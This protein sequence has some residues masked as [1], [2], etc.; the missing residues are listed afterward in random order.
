[1]PTM[2]VP[3]MIA[4]MITYSV[5]FSWNMRSPSESAAKRRR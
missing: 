1:M 5:R 3:K 4:K 2:T